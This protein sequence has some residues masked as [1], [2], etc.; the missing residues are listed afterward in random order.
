MKK[1]V[2]VSLSA[3]ELIVKEGW[4]GDEQNKY[5]EGPLGDVYEWLADVEEGDV[6]YVLRCEDWKDVLETTLEGYD[7]DDLMTIAEGIARDMEE[8]GEKEGVWNFVIFRMKVVKKRLEGEER[9]YVSPV[10]EVWTRKM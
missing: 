7:L 6:F 3:D 2:F 5:V 10:A 8:E 1:K 9:W 4:E